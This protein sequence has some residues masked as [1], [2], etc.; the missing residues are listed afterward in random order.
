MKQ[1]MILLG[2]VVLCT[3]AAISSMPRAISVDDA[4]SKAD[5]IIVGRIVQVHD[6]A[7][8]PALRADSFTTN[9]PPVPARKRRGGTPRG[10][11]RGGR[12]AQAPSR[13]HTNDW[14]RTYQ[15]SVEDC[16]LGSV[17]DGASPIT[18][19]AYGYPDEMRFTGCTAPV[20][21]HNQSYVLMIRRLYDRQAY[22]LSNH[23][24]YCQPASAQNV[25]DIKQAIERRQ[26]HNKKVNR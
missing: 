12:Q 11:A 15:V 16:L 5:I 8:Q 14:V 10:R 17:P 3:T 1:T 24:V 7:L 6:C 21:T 19:M 26:A 9:R 18:V 22:W 25:T 2:S 4:V 20:L 13:P 23:R